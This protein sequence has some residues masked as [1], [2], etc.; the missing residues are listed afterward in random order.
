LNKDANYWIN[1]LN[2][3]EH[4]EGGYF[5]ETYV[6]DML[7]TSPKY[8][9]P[10]YACTAIYYLLVEDQ[11]S[12]FH[13]MRSEE[14]WHFYAGSSLTLHIIGTDREIYNVKLGKNIDNEE[15]FLAAVKSGSWFAASVDDTTSYSLVGCIISPGFDYQDW[16]LG[17]VEALTKLYPQHKSTIEKYTR[18]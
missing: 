18:N 6:S 4:A 9:G 11:F 17:N 8:D 2:L 1:K 7:I 15:K 3:R 5:T 16:K 13:T 12:S 14:L 10:R